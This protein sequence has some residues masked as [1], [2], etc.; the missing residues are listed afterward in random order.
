MREKERKK[1]RK[2]GREQERKKASKRESARVC[3]CACVCLCM[4]QTGSGDARGEKD[5]G[6]HV[7]SSLDSQMNSTLRIGITATSALVQSLVSKY[8]TRISKTELPDVRN[9][10]TQTYEISTDAQVKDMLVWG[11]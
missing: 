2:K 8:L 1:G 10:C 7:M 6:A 9:I 11:K 5:L 3:V 4:L